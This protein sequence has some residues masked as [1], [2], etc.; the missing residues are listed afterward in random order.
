[1][2]WIRVESELPKTEENYCNYSGNYIG[3]YSMYV[4]VYNENY[5]CSK[6]L[7]DKEKGWMKDHSAKFV[8]KIT[9]WMPLPDEPKAI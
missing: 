2:E 9:H 8:D 3:E 4:L 5:G 6:G 7:F 1:M